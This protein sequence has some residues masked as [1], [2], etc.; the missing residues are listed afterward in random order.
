MHREHRG[1][2]EDGGVSAPLKATQPGYGEG[3]VQVEA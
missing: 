2:G 3:T 1:T